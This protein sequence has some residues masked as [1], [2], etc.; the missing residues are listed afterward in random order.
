MHM[1]TLF[2]HEVIVFIPWW[3]GWAC[4]HIVIECTLYSHSHVCC[5][6]IFLLCVLCMHAALLLVSFY[7]NLNTRDADDYNYTQSRHRLPH[8]LVWLFMFVFYFC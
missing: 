6:L 7:M 5:T 8:H 4:F 1:L 2:A 3:A